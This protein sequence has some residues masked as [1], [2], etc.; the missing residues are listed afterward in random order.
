MRMVAR[1]G[2]DKPSK[3]GSNWGDVA[4]G[5]ER[6]LLGNFPQG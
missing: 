6:Y 2:C 4:I 1:L 3:V 5:D